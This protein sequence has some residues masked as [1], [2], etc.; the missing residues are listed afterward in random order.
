MA[1]LTCDEFLNGIRLCTRATVIK[2]QHNF[3]QQI[4][5]CPMGSSLSGALA[6]LVM[7]DLETST[8]EHIPRDTISIF[9]RYVDNIFAFLQWSIIQ[10]LLTVLNAYHPRL[11]FTIEMESN[12]QLPF[13]DVLVTCDNAGLHTMVYAKP[14]AT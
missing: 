1:P 13:L 4:F 5:G 11:Q 12:L 6:N 9:S 2:F 14:T 8:L 3:Y 7:V 10:Q